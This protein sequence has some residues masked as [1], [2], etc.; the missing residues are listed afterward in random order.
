[1]ITA[2]LIVLRDDDPVARIAG[3]SWPDFRIRTAMAAGARHIVVTAERVSGE[4]VAAIDRAARAGASAKL[5]RTTAEAAD[6]FHPDEAVLLLSGAAIAGSGEVE[7]LAAAT[8]PALLCL[9]PEAGDGWELIDARARWTGI[10][11]LTGAQVRA[12]AGME[13]DWDLASTLLRQAVGARASRIMVEAIGDARAPDAARAAG[14]A[15]IDA[16]AMP[17]RGWGER[18]LTGP[19]ARALARVSAPRLDDS[20]RV[21]PWL[22]LGILAAAVLLAVRGVGAAACFALVVAAMLEKL[23]GVAGAVTRRASMVDRWLPHG[24]DAA[25]VIVLAALAA[26]SGPD[27]AVAVLFLVLVVAVTLARRLPVSPEKGWAHSDVAGLAA[28]L[29]IASLFGGVGL[30]VGM[31]I[32]VLAAFASLAWLQDRLSR[33]LTAAR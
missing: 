22:C 27:R 21:L 13:A 18:V 30:L 32:A 25:G 9:P 2:A 5:A 26:W 28:I 6:N 11:R 31:G 23:T 10:A 8:R 4:I 7:K 1:M 33:D 24:V 15:M 14:V 17:P 12:T 3:L 19:F 20:V 29:A 16:A